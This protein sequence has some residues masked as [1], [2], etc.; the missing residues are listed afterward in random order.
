MITFKSL[1]WRNFMSYGNEFTSID[2]QLL[3]TT[4]IVGENGSGKST[5]LDALTFALYGKPFRS[6][7]KPQLL[8]SINNKAA[9]VEIDFDAGPHSYTVRRGIK[10]NIF[11]I[12]RDGTALNQDAM[13]RDQQE[14]LETSIIKM[15]QKSFCQIVVL[16]LANFTPFMQLPAAQRRQVIEDLL[17]IQIFSVMNTLLKE[18]ITQNKLDVQKNGSDLQII[19]SK[20][21]SH[22]KYLED[23]KQNHQVDISLKLKEIDQRGIIIEVIEEVHNEILSHHSKQEEEYRRLQKTKGYYDRLAAY[24]PQLM[25]K[26]EKIDKNIEFYRNNTN[27]PTC[28]QVIV[29]EFALQLISE[30]V[31][32]HNKLSEGVGKLEDDLANLE[33]ELS[34]LKELTAEIKSTMAD[35]Q[36]GKTELTFHRR[37]IDHLNNDIEALKA[38]QAATNTKDDTKTR[39][40]S[41]LDQIASVRDK[42]SHTKEVLSFA[43]A[44]L[45]DG[46]IKGKIINQYIPILNR[47]INR[48]LEAM[49]FFVDFELDKEFKETIR[50]RHRDEFSYDSFSQGEKLRIDLSLMFTWRAI[51]KIRNSATTNLLILDEILDSSLDD[52]GVE[53]FIEIIKTLTKGTNTFIISHKLD[54]VEEFD[55]VITF[56]KRDNFSRIAA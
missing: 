49:D 42:L 44:L 2:F 35:I 43:Q 9:L 22:E 10:P 1:R 32:K 46:G 39:L 54:N 30:E 4:L 3:P 16:G 15:N 50:S 52:K 45:K 28:H 55:R 11:E 14:M 38:K 40:D 24:K 31:E 37:I 17:D 27:C 36:G 12:I 23:M 34:R 29:K 47:L 41:E 51:A 20:L 33:P 6:I 13:S 19:Q 8:N 7:N 26:C 56:E 53:D 48:H 5:M 25:K 18:R 21:E